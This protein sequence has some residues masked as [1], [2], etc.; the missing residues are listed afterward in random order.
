MRFLARVTKGYTWLENQMDISGML[1]WKSVGKLTDMACW[2]DAV[3]NIQFVYFPGEH[4]E[5]RVEYGEYTM[6]YWL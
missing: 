4:V 5:P 6:S 2:R 3:E 1:M